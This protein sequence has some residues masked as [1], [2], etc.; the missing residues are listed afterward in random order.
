MRTAAGAASGE[1]A[2]IKSIVFYRYTSTCDLQDLGAKRISGHSMSRTREA[3]RLIM[4]FDQNCRVVQNVTY[5]NIRVS[6][7]QWL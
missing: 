7:T 5:G 3:L 1:S 6:G 4:T 2:E